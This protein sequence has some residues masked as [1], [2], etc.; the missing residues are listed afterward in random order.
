MRG[1]SRGTIG[2]K[3]RSHANDCCG[4]DS[5]DRAGLAGIFN[6]REL[7]EMRRCPQAVLTAATTPAS[8][9]FCIEVRDKDIGRAA[10]P[11]PTSSGETSRGAGVCIIK[12][13][14]QRLMTINL[15]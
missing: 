8:T 12:K 1:S 14:S 15:A 3:N 4:T 2:H 9:S 6:I 13:C 11:I 7:R 5:G 10:L